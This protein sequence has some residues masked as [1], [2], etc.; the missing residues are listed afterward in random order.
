[1]F[2]YCLIDNQNS[3]VLA[4]FDAEDGERARVKARDLLVT[5]GVERGEICVF[6]GGGNPKKCLVER[7]TG[8]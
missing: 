5:L 4:T 8:N 6:L 1:M 3:R 7:P 2:K